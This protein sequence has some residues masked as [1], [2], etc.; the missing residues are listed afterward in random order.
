MNKGSL[1]ASQWKYESAFSSIG[2]KNALLSLWYLLRRN[3][4]GLLIS[5][6]CWRLKSLDWPLLAKEN[7]IN[8]KRALE[9]RYRNLKHFWKIET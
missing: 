5:E 7:L 3:A 2:G 8:F 1:P 6:F 4:P 9:P